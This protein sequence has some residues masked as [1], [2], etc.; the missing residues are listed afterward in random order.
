[1][2]DGNEVREDFQKLVGDVGA[3]VHTYCEKRPEMAGLMI[4]ALGIYIGWKIKPW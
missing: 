2:K 3:S 1:M 4:F